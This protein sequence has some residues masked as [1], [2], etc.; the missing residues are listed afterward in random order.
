M[1]PESAEEAPDV[2]IHPLMYPES[3]VEA[4]DVKMPYTAYHV[5]AEQ[6]PDVMIHPLMYQESAEKAPDVKM[7]YTMY[8]ESAEEAPGMKIPNID[9]SSHLLTMSDNMYFERTDTLM[10]DLD[11]CTT[12]QLGNNDYLLACG[13]MYATFVNDQAEDNES[14]FE[15]FMKNKSSGKTSRIIAASFN[16]LV[17]E[18]ELEA[19]SKGYQPDVQAQSAGN[20]EDG[21]LLPIVYLSKAVARP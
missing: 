7:P 1:Y 15:E 6:A 10:P 20:Y 21:D 19:Y 16:G 9:T 2:K 17:S 8:Q 5:S 3:A 13:D 4:P 11:S 18:E 14:A 12:P